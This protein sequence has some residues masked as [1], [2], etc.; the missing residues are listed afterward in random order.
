MGVTSTEFITA[1][2]SKT[3]QNLSEMHLIF[4]PFFFKSL[5]GAMQSSNNS[6]F[7][8]DAVRS[9]QNK[10]AVIEFIWFCL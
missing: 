7:K 2:T 9:F 1:N 4:F 6:K 5:L 8:M 3:D 10:L